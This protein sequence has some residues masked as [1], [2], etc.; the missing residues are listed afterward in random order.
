MND[1]DPNPVPGTTPGQKSGRD[2]FPTALAFVVALLPVLVLVATF[3]PDGTDCA[4]GSCGYWFTALTGSKTLIALGAVVTGLWLVAGLMFFLR[5]LRTMPKD[6]ARNAV[7][8]Y[9]ILTCAFGFFILPVALV[10]VFG[11]YLFSEAVLRL[12]R[13]D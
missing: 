9:V 2:V 8:L 7:F 3:L 10:T 4:P 12:A 1:A 6:R 13:R 5:K 11:V